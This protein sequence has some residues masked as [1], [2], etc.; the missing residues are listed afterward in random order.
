MGRDQSDRLAATKGRHMRILKTLID[1]YLAT[2]VICST[3]HADFEVTPG[4]LAQRVRLAH[5]RRAI[6]I[7][8][9]VAAQ[10]GA[11][12]YHESST[13]LVIGVADARS[14]DRRD[15]VLES[16]SQMLRSLGFKVRIARG[17]LVVKRDIAFEDAARALAP[18]YNAR[19]QSELMFGNADTVR[20][21]A[22]DFSGEAASAE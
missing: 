6:E 3:T 13:D 5:A 20:P 9:A 17:V 7:S 19:L 12:I 16:I 2:D 14:V 1:Q 22:L 15:D 4:L 18:A 11:K 21:T 10:L 8:S